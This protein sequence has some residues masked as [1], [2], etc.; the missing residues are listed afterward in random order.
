MVCGTSWPPKVTEISLST[1][2]RGSSSCQYWPTKCLLV[3]E[4]MVLIREVRPDP[5]SP[6]RSSIL[7]DCPCMCSFQAVR[8]SLRATRSP[9]LDLSMGRRSN[10][11]P[12]IG[13]TSGIETSLTTIGYQ[14]GPE[15]LMFTHPHASQKANLRVLEKNREG[16]L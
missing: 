10:G 14:R 6:T 12:L 4:D 9:A 2:F 1:R 16:S 7:G 8:I 3:C 13:G 11:L 15:F 5:L